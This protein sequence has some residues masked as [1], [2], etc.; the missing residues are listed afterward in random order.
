M[1]TIGFIGGGNMAQ[2]LLTGI[3]KAGLYHA[4]HIWVSD[5][6]LEQLDVLK[7]LYGIHTT[8]DNKELTARA[9]VIVL[10]VKPQVMGDVLD[11]V[12]GT[13]KDSVLVISIAAGITTDSNGCRINN[14]VQ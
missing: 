5:I 10:S 7:D 8:D 13:L 3:L 14:T 2:A 1:K 11:G 12:A 9:D 4:N 6:R